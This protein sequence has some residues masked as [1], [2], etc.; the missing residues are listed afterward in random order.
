MIVYEDALVQLRLASAAAAKGHLMLVP[1]KKTVHL[2]DLDEE[3][4]AHFFLVASYAAAIIFQGLKAE[5][6]NIIVEEQDLVAHIIGRKSDDGLNFQWKP[7]ESDEG[8]LNDMQEAIKD[9]AFMIGKTAAEEQR[10]P[11]TENELQ[12]EE[13]RENYLI[14]QLIRIP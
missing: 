4:S 10:E 5:G 11:M 14:K 12:D 1:K 6:T 13:E 3:E 7:G 9:K 2:S 8:T